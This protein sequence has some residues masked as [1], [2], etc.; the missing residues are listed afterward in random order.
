M[1]LLVEGMERKVTVDQAAF[2]LSFI[3]TKH[4]F[5]AAEEI[6][7]QVCLPSWRLLPQGQAG[8]TTDTE[9]QLFLIT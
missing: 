9:I 7:K 3:P 1:N 2:T 6:Y 5:K 4:I 8:R